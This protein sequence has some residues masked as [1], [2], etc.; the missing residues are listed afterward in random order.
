MAKE[1]KVNERPI[2]PAAIR[3]PDALEILRIWI[4]ERS[5]QTSIR[6][7]VYKDSNVVE[8]KAWG[9]ILADTARHVAR[10]LSEEVN[11][12]AS[13]L[14]SRIVRSFTNEIGDPTSETEGGFIN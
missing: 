11:V 6:I 8:E 5:L 1:M 7:G 10:G 12:G 9:I 2:P 13:E 3:D 14:L 4:A